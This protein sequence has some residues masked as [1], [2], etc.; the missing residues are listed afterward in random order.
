MTHKWLKTGAAVEPQG[1]RDRKQAL[2][3]ISL[4]WHTSFRL[5]SR[6]GSRSAP[7][8]T[9]KVMHMYIRQ[10]GSA[11]SQRKSK[12]ASKSLQSEAISCSNIFKDN[13]HSNIRTCQSLDGTLH[14]NLRRRVDQ[15]K[16]TP[17]LLCLL[18]WSKIRVCKLPQKQN[19]IR[20]RPRTARVKNSGLTDAGKNM[21]MSLS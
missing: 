9:N 5:L 16:M 10:G 7:L 14:S 12:R 13:L 15:V 20:H 17:A 19:V 2:Q 21:A 18:T 8:Q 4:I 3:R 6:I 1:Y 11:A